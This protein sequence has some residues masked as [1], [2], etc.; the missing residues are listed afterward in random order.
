[1]SKTVRTIATRTLLVLAAAVLLVPELLA[2]AISYPLGSTQPV[3]Q[4]L[5]AAR[6]DWR[7]DPFSGE[8]RWASCTLDVSIDA[9]AGAYR[10]EILEGLDRVSALTGMR[11]NVVDGPADIEIRGATTITSTRGGR[12]LTALGTTDVTATWVA[13]VPTIDHAVIDLNLTALATQN[14]GGRSP[15]LT[16]VHEVGHALGLDHVDD[17]ASL[18]YY[19]THADT[20]PTAADRAAFAR[21]GRCG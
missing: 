11:L 2:K 12:T 8:A 13:G 21:A 19:A 18:M 6:L 15:V 3:A 14:T 7:P 17:P 1:M 16:V 4:V 5:D 10:P 9:R 20:P